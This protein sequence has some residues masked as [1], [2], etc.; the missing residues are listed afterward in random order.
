MI[1]KKKSP[2]NK[3]EEEPYS[4]SALLLSSLDLSD[5]KVYESQIRALQREQVGASAGHVTCHSPC[6]LQGDRHPPSTLNLNPSTLVVRLE[7]ARAMS[8]SEADTITPAYHD[9]R[10]AHVCSQPRNPKLSTPKHETVQPRKPC[11]SEPSATLDSHHR[12]ARTFPN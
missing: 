9:M 12:S 2:S 11:R 10:S 4:S 7:Q 5:K 6:L 8:P 1:T 3:E